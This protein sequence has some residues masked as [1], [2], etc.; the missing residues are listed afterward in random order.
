LASGLKK[1]EQKEVFLDPNFKL[2]F[3]AK[4]L[5]TNTAYLSQYFN[6]VMQKTFSEYTQELRINYV[7]Q[8]LIDAPYFRKYTLQAIAEEV[9]Y[10]DANTL[11]RVFKKQTGLSPNY[12]IEKLKNTE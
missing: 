12:Y 7:L 11:V 1:L 3:V 2:A 6:Q 5:N 10:K 4:K 9:G 8:K